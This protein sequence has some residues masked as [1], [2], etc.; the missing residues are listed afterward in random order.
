MDWD[1]YFRFLLALVFV[2]GLIG[3]IA[4]LARRYGVGGI[5]TPP[6]GRRRRLRVVEIAAIDNKRRLVLVRRDRAEHL[7]LLGP[8][9][10]SVVETGIVPPEPAGAE[11]EETGESA[12]GGGPAPKSFRERLRAIEPTRALGRGSRGGRAGKRA[13]G[14][15]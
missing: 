14:A 4:W 6:V 8:A 15:S 7:L 9:S 5:A 1:I 10:E 11:E 3:L 2:V 13:E 12:A